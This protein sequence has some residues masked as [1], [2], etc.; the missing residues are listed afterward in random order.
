MAPADFEESALRQIRSKVDRHLIA[1]PDDLVDEVL[2]LLGALESVLLV[3]AAVDSTAAVQ[4][5]R[6]CG[7]ALPCAS[8]KVIR[9]ELLNVGSIP[10]WTER[11]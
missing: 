11:T 5:C 8:R 10:G 1:Q 6:T 2:V 4:V 3:H 7:S 9:D